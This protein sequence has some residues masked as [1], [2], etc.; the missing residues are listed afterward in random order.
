MAL[1]T[2]T[3][4]ALSTSLMDPVTP[5]IQANVAAPSDAVNPGAVNAL[6]TE[7]FPLL[8]NV[9]GNGDR[10]RAAVGTVGITAI[11]SEGT[12]ATY[13]VAA[14]GMTLAATATDFFQITG[15]SSK[16]IRVTRIQIS[17]IATAAA[18]VDIQLVKRTAVNT[19]GTSSSL[20][21][22]IV[23]HDSNSASATASVNQYSVN[24]SALG[25]GNP[26]RAQKLALGTSTNPLPAIVWD[27]TTRNS[28]GLV[29]RAAA[30]SL[31]LNWNG[32]SVPAGTALDID[33][34]WTEE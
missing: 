10:A 31:N 27:F 30:Q 5:S 1:Q 14:L 7:A 2:S 21:T 12:K 15:S 3:S 24:P 8:M 29:L 13:S 34:E 9:S 17:G 32:S 26:L 6:V 25:A 16:T 33:I 19:G 28:Q 18:S 23:P 22:S 20:S 11:N 4:G